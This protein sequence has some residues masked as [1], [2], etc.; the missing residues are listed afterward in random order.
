MSRTFLR[1]KA[2]VI[3]LLFA[4]QP[5]ICHAEPS[6]IPRMEIDYTMP[7]VIRAEHVV[8]IAA[9]LDN[10]K[11]Q[12]RH[13]NLYSERITPDKTYH[14]KIHHYFFSI[15]ES[16]DS[17]TLIILVSPKPVDGFPPFDGETLYEYC[18]KDNTFKIIEGDNLLIKLPEK[19]Y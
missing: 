1:L 15:S 9:V 14:R 17:E 11:K 12:I 3:T 19:K 7:M 6:S 2:V 13:Q 16:E 18:L 8:A 10:Y 5:V 4:L